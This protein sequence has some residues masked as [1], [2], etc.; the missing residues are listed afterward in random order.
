MPFCCDFLLVAG[1]CVNDLLFGLRPDV[2]RSRTE[3]PSVLDRQP[4]GPRPTSF[5]RITPF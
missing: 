3:G 5:S 4:L 2:P 1:K